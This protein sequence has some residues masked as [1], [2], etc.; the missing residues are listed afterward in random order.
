MQLA[1]EPVTFSYG[2]GLLRLI[3]QAR[4]FNGDSDLPADGGE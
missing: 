3:I 1:R 4:V 2:S